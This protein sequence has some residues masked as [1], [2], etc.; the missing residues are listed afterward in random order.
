MTLM[1]LKQA[2]NKWNFKVQLLE[3]ENEELKLAAFKDKEGRNDKIKYKIRQRAIFYS[4]ARL[5]KKGKK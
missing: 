4:K 3:K 1:R 2:E 5:A